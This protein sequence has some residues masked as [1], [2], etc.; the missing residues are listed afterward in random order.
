MVQANATS[1]GP[2]PDD[3][4]T[5]FPCTQMRNSKDESPSAKPGTLSVQTIRT[6][7]LSDSRRNHSLSNSYKLLLQIAHDKLIL[8]L[9]E[10]KWYKLN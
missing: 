7:H 1:L 2:G 4:F 10:P 6:S 3:I 5:Y 8:R 9:Q